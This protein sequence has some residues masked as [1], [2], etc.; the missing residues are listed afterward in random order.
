[1][2]D[3]QLRLIVQQQALEKES[4]G[5]KMFVGLSVNETLRQCILAGWAK[6]ADKLRSDFKVSGELCTTILTNFISHQCQSGQTNGMLVSTS[7]FFFVTSL[8]KRA[9]DAFS[10]CSDTG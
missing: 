3:E 6:K 9:Y 10:Y 4:D 2:A 1:M 7:I 5:R 8:Q